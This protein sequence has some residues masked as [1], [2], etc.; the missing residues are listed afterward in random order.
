MYGE[1][2]PRRVLPIWNPLMRFTQP[3]AFWVQA[4]DYS[5][6]GFRR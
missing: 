5:A 6:L 1:G 3:F 4:L 2:K